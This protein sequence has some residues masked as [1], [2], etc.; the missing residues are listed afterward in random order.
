MASNI[1]KKFV[2]SLIDKLIKKDKI[3]DKQ[4]C[5]GQ[6]SLYIN[7]DVEIV[8]TIAD[9]QTIVKAPN[10]KAKS[11]V[12]SNTATPNC[13]II[14][15]TPVIKENFASKLI[16]NASKNVQASPEN[17]QRDILAETHR[18]IYSCKEFVR[19]DIVNTFYEDYLEFKYYINDIIK[20]ITP[21]PDLV[22]DFSNENTSLI[23]KITPLEEEI[24][25][26]KDENSNLKN[27]I[28]TQLTIIE[29][30]SKFNKDNYKYS[31][32]GKDKEHPN[33]QKENTR[34]ENWQIAHSKTK[35]ASTATIK[36]NFVERNKKPNG[37]N[38]ELTNHFSPV[39]VDNINGTRN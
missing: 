33:Y 39:Y 23:T 3:F 4:T 35:H 25:I 30:L 9:T 31:V 34:N 11:L 14:T 19:N 21:N 28:K 38:L 26:L 12:N 13:D 27:N 1:D 15:E 6:D 8:G 7:I 20:T 24:K 32:T 36:S 17:S 5:K 29:N 2:V 37:I 18:P 10:K 22:T 16:H